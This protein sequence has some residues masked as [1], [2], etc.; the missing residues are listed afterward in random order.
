MFAWHIEGERVLSIMYE[1]HRVDIP[2]A[3]LDEYQMLELT[4]DT[5][6][7]L[8]NEGYEPPLFFEFM[9]GCSGSSKRKLP[10]IRDDDW[11]NWASIWKYAKMGHS[12]THASYPAPSKHQQILKELDVAQEKEDQIGWTQTTLKHVKMLLC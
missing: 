4:K 12:Y 3:D 9:F 8:I 11:L 1:G 2:H 6:V 7:T 5:K 10:L